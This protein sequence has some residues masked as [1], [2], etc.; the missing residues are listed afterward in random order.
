MKTSVVMA[1]YNSE[2]TI[3]TA[4]ESFLA[5]DHPDK[6]LIVIDG[7]STDRT[8]EIVRGFDS[9]LIQLHSGPDK[10]IYDAMNKGLRRVSGEAFGCL[11]SDDRYHDAGVLGKLA[12]ALQ[13]ADLVSGRLHFVRE[14]GSA[15]VRVWQADRHRPGAY[16]RGFTLPHPATYARRA[17]LERVGD[18]STDFRSAGD[19]DWLMRALEVEG[20]SHSVIED[21]IVDMRIGGESTGGA[22]AILKNSREMLEIRRRRLGSGVVDAALFLNLFIKFKQ[23]LLR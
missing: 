6:E 5:Q 1:A 4:I 16:A 7:A 19:Y 8:C 14:H 20:F 17:V 2:A 18:F 11:N 10:G 21:V 12:R 3:G 23:V 9:P 13:G 22:K 15:P